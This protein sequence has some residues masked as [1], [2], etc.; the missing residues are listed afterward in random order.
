[1]FEVLQIIAHR[2]H[3]EVV[4]F[5]PFPIVSIIFAA[6]VNIFDN[7]FRLRVKAYETS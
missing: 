4:L 3:D 7:F 2:M 6:S 5:M 1:M